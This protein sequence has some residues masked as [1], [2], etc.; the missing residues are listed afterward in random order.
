MEKTRYDHVSRSTAYRRFAF[1]ALI[2]VTA[3]TYLPHV[4]DEV[5]AITG[6]GRTFVGSFFVALSTS[7]PEVVV[8]REAIRMGTFDLAV[9]NLLGSNLFN[10]AILAID[11]FVYPHGPILGRISA[12]HALTATAAMTMTAVMIVA[13]IYRSKKKSPLLFMGFS[14]TLCYL[15]TDGRPV[16]FKA[17]AHRVCVAL[18]RCNSFFG[19][20]RTDNP[21]VRPPRA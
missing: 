12:N 6:L 17:L 10:I 21:K 7:L 19:V 15:C 14:R 18:R 8:S 11:D 2:I 5:A 4:A 13:L 9:G 20:N 1:Y 16:V 3:A